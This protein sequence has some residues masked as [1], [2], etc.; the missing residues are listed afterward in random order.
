MRSRK[1]RAHPLAHFASGFIG[2]SDGKNLVSGNPFTDKMI[3]TR[4]EYARFPA[5]GAGE[6][7]NGTVG[8]EHRALLCVIQDGS[9][10]EYN[11]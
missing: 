7:R 5:P 6:D 2:E 4:R 9:L 10:S 11:A 1:H 8:G 3:Y